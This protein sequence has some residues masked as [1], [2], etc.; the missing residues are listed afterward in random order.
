MKKFLKLTLGGL[1]TLSLV[2]CGGDKVTLVDK[3]TTTYASDPQRLDYVVT[4]LAV[5]HDVNTN[6]VDGLLEN[7]QYGNYVGAIAE[8]WKPNE[9][10]TVWTFTLR[11]GVKWVTS[12]GDEYADVTAN[13]FVAG[14]QHAADYN[15]GTA[16]L[17]RGVIKNFSEYE[18]GK[19][20]W[21]EVGVKAVDDYT[22]DYDITISDFGTNFTDY[23][24][25]MVRIAAGTLVDK[26]DEFVEGHSKNLSKS[27]DFY[28]GN[29]NWVE[30][31]DNATNPI[32]TAFRDSY[33][34]F[35]APR[36]EY[37]YDGGQNPEIDYENQTVTVGFKVLEKYIYTDGL[38]KDEFQKT[39][40]D[41][42]KDLFCNYCIN[43]NGREYYFA[44]M[45]FYYWEKKKW[46]EK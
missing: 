35:V 42:A 44:E 30:R 41:I 7:D 8:S 25:V 40:S 5:D 29:S 17:M 13:D 1:M 20:S 27:A 14:L 23:G 15:S 33:V 43:C 16:M 45:E 4:A 19:V 6:L 11:E 18:A 34:D 24:K 39:C 28:V 26:A 12:T 32:Y 22:L 3:L 46:N 37:Q 9:D 21:E 31:D 10:A 36:I 38:T 2:A